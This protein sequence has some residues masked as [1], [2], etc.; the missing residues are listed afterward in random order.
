MCP[1]NA[2]GMAN[3]VDSDQTDLVWVYTVCP[4]LSVGKLRIV[5]VYGF[6]VAIHSTLSPELQLRWRWNNLFQS[7]NGNVYGHIIISKRCIFSSL[8]KK[9]WDCFFL[10]ALPLTVLCLKVNASCIVLILYVLCFI[11]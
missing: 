4:D 10:F 5:T 8:Q 6:R 7:I 1:N 11:V 3:S 9:S 2:D